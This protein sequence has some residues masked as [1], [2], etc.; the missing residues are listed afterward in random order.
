MSSVRVRRLVP[1]RATPASVR[2]SGAL[3]ATIW[4]ANPDAPRAAR[5]RAE[6]EHL[7]MRLMAAGGVRMAARVVDTA[8]VG[9]RPLEPTERTATIRAWK[10]DDPERRVSLTIRLHA[11]R[12][13]RSSSVVVRELPKPLSR[14]E[15]E[16]KRIQDA[17]YARYM[18]AGRRAYAKPPARLSRADRIVLLVGELEADVNNGG[19]RQ[20]LDNKGR[21]RAAAARAALEAIGA[22][23]TAAMLASAM[24]RDAT[25]AL[26]DRLD[27]RFYAVPE[28]L[29]VLAMKALGAP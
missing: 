18:A 17:F 20:Y 3:L 10:L 15:A 16:T 12:D 28:D 21:R 24:A 13:F 1:L 27:G 8:L 4:R 14:R 9:C 11:E 26:L 5:A 19:F 22:K 6:L 25:P 7:L 29:G 23:R 2:R